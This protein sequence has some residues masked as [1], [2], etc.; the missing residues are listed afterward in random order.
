ML[1]P[2]LI[3]NAPEVPTA[4]LRELKITAPADGADLTQELLAAS[5]RYSE[6]LT[7]LFASNIFCAARGDFPNL[8]QKSLDSYSPQS[9]YFSQ[10]RQTALASNKNCLRPNFFASPPQDCIYFSLNRFNLANLLPYCINRQTRQ[11]I[12]QAHLNLGCGS[13]Q[14]YINLNRAEHIVRLRHKWAAQEGYNNFL[15]YS[16]EA[17]LIDSPKAIVNF[18]E[19]SLAEL[20]PK[21]KKNHSELAKFAHAKYNIHPMQPWDLLFIMK[22]WTREVFG[23]DREEIEKYFPLATTLPKIISF[24][25]QLFA[26]KFTPLPDRKVPGGWEYLV[27]AAGSTQTLG[28]IRLY[29]NCNIAHRGFGMTTC[30]TVTPD[31]AGDDLCSAPEIICAVIEASLTTDPFGRNGFLSLGGISTLFHELGHALEYILAPRNSSYF[32]KLTDDITEF[33]SLFMEKFCSCWPVIEKLSNHYQTGRQMPR[34]MFFAD[35]Q[36]DDFNASFYWLLSLTKSLLDLNINLHAGCLAEIINRTLT[37]TQYTQYGYFNPLVDR[38]LFDH[39]DNNYYTGNAYTYLLSEKLADDIFSS[40]IRNKPQGVAA[41]AGKIFR[42]KIWGE[43]AGQDFIEIY[44]QIRGRKFA[45]APPGEFQQELVQ[46]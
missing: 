33:S 4:S 10:F 45:F 18:L 17:K 22:Q 40:L 46:R 31:I 20:T 2:P 1:N 16:F 42:E 36:Y 32:G 37:R 12:V 14:Q 23:Y 28:I 34:R 6:N 25:E 21:T 43:T 9:I 13:E 11:K 44:E 15:E 41:G 30:K 24:I 35:T 27:T 8:P 38:Y 5:E 7:Q 39:P 19:Q 29:V 26:L 3:G